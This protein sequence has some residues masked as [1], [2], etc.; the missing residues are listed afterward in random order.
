MMMKYELQCLVGTEF[1]PMLLDLINE[2]SWIL[3][4]DPRSTDAFSNF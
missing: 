1:K 4:L 3:L 2:L